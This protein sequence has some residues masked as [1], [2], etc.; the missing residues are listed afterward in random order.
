MKW[1]YIE[2]NTSK[3]PIY[4]QSK[5]CST[6]AENYP[7][8]SLIFSQRSTILA[9]VS[10]PKKNP[11][12]G[13]SLMKINHFIKYRSVFPCSSPQGHSNDICSS[14][15]S[16]RDIQTY[17]KWAFSTLPAAFLGTSELCRRKRCTMLILLS[18]SLLPLDHM[19]KLHPVAQK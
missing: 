14:C 6:K 18:Q 5:F 2:Q 11:W 3:A 16:S 12:D 15:D 17:N 7:S 9:A 19:W 1:L 13:L 10:H 4:Y 8:G